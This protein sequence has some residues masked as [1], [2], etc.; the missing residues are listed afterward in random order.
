VGFE[1]N[2]RAASIIRSINSILASE[3]ERVQQEALHEAQTKQQIAD[4]LFRRNEGCITNIL[5]LNNF[6]NCYQDLLSSEKCQKIRQ[7]L[8]ALKMNAES[9]AVDELLSMKD[10]LFE[11]YHEEVGYLDVLPQIDNAIDIVHHRDPT[12]ANQLFHIKNKMMDALFKGSSETFLALADQALEIANAVYTAH[13]ARNYHIHKD[14][15]MSL[16]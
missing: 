14:L 7:A 15:A 8:D 11:V 10:A 2:I 12:K 9:A 16:G 13:T 1:Y 5:Y 3:T 6:L 4:E